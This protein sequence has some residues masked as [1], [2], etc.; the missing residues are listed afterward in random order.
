M[1]MRLNA[2]VLAAAGLMTI[3][4]ACE[5][6]PPNGP[7]PVC[8]YTV[9]VASL[10]FPAQGGSAAVGVTTSTDCTWTAASDRSWLTITSGSNGTGSGSVNVAASANPDAAARTG[11]LT[12]AGQTVTVIED[13]KTTCTVTVAPPAASFGDEAATGSVAVTSPPN[14]PWTAVSTA[15]WLTVTGGSPGQGNGTVSYALA[16]NNETTARSAALNINEAR[17]AVTQAGE[18]VACQYSVTPVQFTPCM[19]APFTMSAIVTTQAACSWT[20]T[21]AAPW[22]NLVEGQSGSGS[23]VVSFRVTDNWDA[24]RA[25][26]VQ[27][28][29]P[30][31]TAGQNLQVAQ[32]GCYYG[33][34]T[35][36]V[37]VPADGGQG[38]FEVLQQSDP[39]TCGG[40][41]QNA[42]QWTAESATSWITITTPMPQTGDHP[43]R[44]TV[45][46]NSTG[47]QRSGTITVRGKT[48]TITQ[49]SL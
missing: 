18:A 32:A 38:Q 7:T 20:A 13:A 36:S 24:P 40:P 14:C 29:W 11:V 23:G 47:S 26:V 44:F 17:F 45:T 3:L 9:S 21:A 8:T 43:V 48:V 35:T 19:S 4:V 42:C 27:V 28:R 12:I 37:A 39:M 6:D 41:T 1:T 34:S 22:I 10:S 33:V 5:N 15:P 2:G 25:G 30:T 16:A 46:P 49:G 31:E